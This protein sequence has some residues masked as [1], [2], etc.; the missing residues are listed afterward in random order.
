[1]NTVLKRSW[2]KSIFAV[3]V[4]A[5]ALFILAACEDIQGKTDAEI[6]AMAKE[7]VQIAYQTGDTS[8]SVT[9]NITLPGSLT[10]EGK[11]VTITWASSNEDIIEIDG[12]TG[13]VTRP[14]N[15]NVELL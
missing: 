12:S 2:L 11:Q 3:F 13:K 9:K 1:M 4:I 5:L 6:L 14:A 7:Q 8:V 10:V 15:A